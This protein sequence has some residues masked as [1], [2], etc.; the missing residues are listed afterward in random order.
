LNIF[1]LFNRITVSLVDKLQVYKGRAGKY[2]SHFKHYVD[3]AGVI[4]DVGCGEGVF[5]RALACQG[6]LVI[7]LALEIRLLREIENSHVEKVC[8]DA[9]HLLLHDGSVDCILSLLEHLKNPGK[10]VEELLAHNA[11]S[12]TLQSPKH[13]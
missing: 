9:H 3:D 8:A 1:K 10:C 6:R 12:M 11:L 13:C 2:L 5:S 4:V 7:A